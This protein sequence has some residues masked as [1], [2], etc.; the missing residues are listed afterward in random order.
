M[1]TVPEQLANLKVSEET[2][3]PTEVVPVAKS[4]KK[5]DTSWRMRSQPDQLRVHSFHDIPLEINQRF[6]TLGGAIWDCAMVLSK[7]LEKKYEATFW[8]GKKVLELGAGTG[9]V[10]LS[11][12]LS[13]AVVTL[14]DLETVL[15]EHMNDNIKRNKKNINQN[16]VTVTKHEW[17]NVSEIKQLQ[18]ALPQVDVLLAS[19]AWPPEAPLVDSMRALCG[20]QTVIYM[21]Y[22]RRDKVPEDMFAHLDRYFERETVSE[23]QLDA[24]CMYISTTTLTKSSQFF[25][26]TKLDFLFICDCNM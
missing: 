19:D 13:G 7:F 14:T 5:Y 25:V 17:G 2:K 22:Q 8:K 24:V 15:L 6:D 26:W 10:G 23:D 4:D 9:F 18:Q 16:N 11:T 12:A 21:C 3:E 1:S 20:E